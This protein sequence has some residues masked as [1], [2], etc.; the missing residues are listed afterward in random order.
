MSKPSANGLTSNTTSSSPG[1]T[2]VIS[3]VLG[4]GLTEPILCQAEASKVSSTPAKSCHSG[5]IT[6]TTC[7]STKA[8]ESRWYSTMNLSSAGNGETSLSLWNQ[9]S[10]S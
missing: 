7:G 6:P 5:R 8:M 4:G 9:S 3:A 1:S 2:K 10:L